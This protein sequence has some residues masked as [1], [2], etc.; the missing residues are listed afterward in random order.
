MMRMKPEKILLGQVNNGARSRLIVSRSFREEKIMV[1]LASERW[2]EQLYMK[3]CFSFGLITRLIMAFFK[4]E[5]CSCH[6]CSTNRFSSSTIIK[7][8]RVFFLLSFNGST[9]Y[10]S[11]INRAQRR[12]P[13]IITLL[14]IYL[15]KEWK[16][17]V[18][19]TSGCCIR[20][21]KR[22]GWMRDGPI[23]TKDQWLTRALSSARTSIRYSLLDIIIVLL[24]RGE[25][26]LLSAP[27]PVSIH[28]LTCV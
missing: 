15:L 11:L 3:E 4:R 28:L 18:A 21:V 24:S 22:W 8:C 1:V 12:P 27:L 25:R 7:R 16:G 13:L 5:W 19:V 17:N 2:D 14:Y 9:Q 23:K 26:A 20:D 10:W 6:H